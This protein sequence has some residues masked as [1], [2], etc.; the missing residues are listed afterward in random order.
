M[1]AGRHRHRR[2]VA[3][4]V[5]I[6]A[7]LLV[8]L[9][10]WSQPPTAQ[11]TRARDPTG[12]LS[13]P[14]IESPR[15][16][17]AG[18]NGHVTARLVDANLRPVT[19]TKLACGDFRSISNGAGEATFLLA[20]ASRCHVLVD[21]YTSDPAVVV[22]DPAQAGPLLVLTRT[23]PGVVRVIDEQGL[24]MSKVAVALW[25]GALADEV[26]TGPLGEAVANS[27][28]CSG[29]AF[30]QPHQDEPSTATGGFQV[31]AG[32]ELLLVAPRLRTALVRMVDGAGVVVAGTIAGQF[33]QER[34]ADGVVAITARAATMEAVA[35]VDGFVP[36]TA[37][38]A[39]DG[40]IHD[41]VM[42]PGRLV[43]LHATCDPTG[44]PV[45]LLCDDTA[46]TGDTATFTCRCQD[47]DRGSDLSSP[48]SRIH[49][50]IAQ[51]P[52]FVREA[53]VD[54]RDAFGY[55]TGR[56][57][58]SAPCVGAARS[59]GTSGAFTQY[60]FTC[61]EHGVFYSPPML[62]EGD[63][64]VTIRGP[65]DERANVT[66]HLTHAQHRDLG[67]VFPDDAEVFGAVYADFPLVGATLDVGTFQ[68]VDLPMD[69]E[70]ALPIPPGSTHVHLVLWSP[71]YGRYD[72]DFPV[73][74]PV[75][76][77]V[78]WQEGA[79][80]PDSGAGDTGAQ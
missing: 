18:V 27:R 20:D 5:A 45:P 22:L 70:F 1:T 65:D 39:A 67:D 52:P 34:R 4:V 51:V 8:L 46:C 76:W 11:V 7:L 16:P 36:T 72:R 38:V 56:W 55:V 26:V 3:L 47:T 63:W 6:A 30:I 42:L 17:D 25:A 61:D 33:T 28:P 15:V 48:S 40:V 29:W 35:T 9:F 58:G 75:L 24:G 2:R 23:C 77:S 14:A 12:G 19:F 69:G 57:K 49:G 74:E 13:A 37:Q 71:I 62:A 66:T 79:P 32:E 31:G 10:R 44:C 80:P 78:Q 21:G 43:T 59:T 60:P 73:N 50:S 54:L 64:R 53:D 41:I 68:G